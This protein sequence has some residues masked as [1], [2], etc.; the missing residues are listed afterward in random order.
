[1]RARRGYLAAD[2]ALSTSSTSTASDVGES[3][4]VHGALAQLGADNQ[5]AALRVLAAAAWT[6]REPSTP[7]VWVTGELGGVSETKS[8]LADGAV[9]VV[10]VTSGSSLAAGTVSIAPGTRTFSLRVPGPTA[11]SYPAEYTV[12]ATIRRH[13]EIVATQTSLLEIPAQ[14]EPV[15]ARWFRRDASRQAPEIPTA[16]LR[17]R[18]SECLRVEIPSAGGDFVSAR[19]LDRNGGAL[20]LPLDVAVRTDGD[21][22][23]WLSAQAILAPLAPGEYVIELSSESRR[24]LSAFRLVH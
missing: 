22:S 8:V 4:T 7:V 11:A 15:G 16:D 6:E 23:R 20:P 18:R 12:R 14:L 10:Q 5:P 19:L 21:G 1:V 2:T 3:A 9:A 13:D 24:T 17:F